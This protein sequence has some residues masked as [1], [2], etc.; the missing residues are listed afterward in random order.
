MLFVWD[1]YGN[2]VRTLSAYAL[3]VGGV[4]GLHNVSLAVDIDSP[5]ALNATGMTANGFTANW[6]AVAGASGYLLDVFDGIPAMT[7]HEGFDGYPGATPIGWVIENGGGSYTTSGNFGQKSPSVQLSATGHAVTTPAYPAAATNLSFWYKGNNASSS[8][9]QVDGSNTTGWATLGTLPVSNSAMTTNFMLSASSGYTRFRLMYNKG[10]GN[11]GI[12][13]VS[14]SYGS[15]TKVAGLSDLAVGNVTSYAIA[16]LAPGV[17]VYVVRATDGD[18]VS[19]DSNMIAVDMPMPPRIAPV[20]AQTIRVG[21]TL[22]F[23][24]TIMP[25]DGDPVTAT[26][27]S[28][29]AGVAGVW[30]LADGLFTYTP[31][32]GDVGERFFSFTAQDKDGWSAAVTAS[33]RVLSFRMAAVSMSGAMGMYAQ[34]FDVLSQSGLDNMWDNAVDPLP[35]WYAHTGSQEVTTYRAGTGSGTIGGIHSFGA[36]NSE[37][38]ALGSLASGGNTLRYGVAFTNTTGQAVTNLSVRFNAAQWR[39]GASAITNTLMF[40]YCITNQI[41]PL[42][43][44]VWRRV[45]ALCFDSPLVT[46]GTQSAGAVSMAPVTL[47]AN[48]T[49]PIPPEDVVMLRWSDKDDP[50]NDHGFGIDDVAV[51][52]AA[53]A[54]PDAITVSRA[55]AFEDF[56]E[57]GDDASR[58][59]PW[60]WRI[61]TRDDAPRMSGAY[62]AASERVTYTNNVPLNPNSYRFTSGTTRDQAVGGF[63]GASQA[64]SISVF[65]KFRNGTVEP[66][67]RWN[68]RFAVEKYKNGF[69]G[70]A[71]RLLRSTDGA[72]WVETGAAVAFPADAD[73]LG[74]P[75]AASPD[76][77]V[78]A[79]QRV[80]FDAP[81]APG[82]IF[83]LAWQI[84]VTEGNAAA[85]AQALA[86]DDVRIEPIFSRY[87]FITL[88]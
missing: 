27:A 13:D 86:I 39:V 79:E 85:D 35:S 64:K 2:D 66:V 71:V 73:T 24:L 62:Q 81:I 45:N 44:G 41:L 70:C 87:H 54:M 47:S 23:G 51:S 82:E 14:V 29:S 72:A 31:V 33:V 15:G 12:D 69:A 18:Q 16:G 74:F 37:N 80:V 75:T 34:D 40:E 52:W 67:R 42:H 6:N 17:Y 76:E 38:R 61:E 77:T 7:V 65:A 19:T 49:R 3:L 57:M 83:Y 53:S 21:E 22:S 4:C 20:P 11:V 88:K 1:R 55:G 48:I 28:A 43:Q 10:I 9:L 5:V 56:N 32:M 50:G 63:S 8:T 25:T 36:V 78:A 46:N 59:L 30:G 26:N 68:V 84:S 60:M 58:E